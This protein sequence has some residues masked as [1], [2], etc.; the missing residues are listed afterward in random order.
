MAGATTDNNAGNHYQ[1]TTG[2]TLNLP[3]SD[4]V[5]GQVFKCGG[6]VPAVGAMVYLRTV[7]NDNSGSKGNSAELSGLVDS[8]G[9]WYANLGNARIQDLTAYFS[10]SASGDSLAAFAEGGSDGTGSIMVDTAGDTPVAGIALCGTVSPE[11]FQKTGPANGA[12]GQSTSPRLSWE[13]SIGAWG[14]E[15]CIDESNDNA[16]TGWTS[17][18]TL[19]SIVVNG[20]S[21]DKTYY[22]QVRS[23]GPG[24]TTYANGSSTAFWSFATQSSI[25]TLKVESAATQDGWILESA[26]TSS[27]GGSLNATAGSFFLGDNAAD[28]Q[29]RSIL[30]FNTSSLPDGAVITGVTLKIKNAGLVGTNPFTTHGNIA[31]DVRKGG[32]SANGALQVQDFQALASKN[33]AMTIM[34]NPVNG[35][36]SKAMAAANF[37]YINKT[38]VTQFR[39]RFGKDDNDDRGADYLKFYSGN[40]ATASWRPQLIIRYYVP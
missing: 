16:C 31:V 20:L 14:Y 7:D 2:P 35:W 36:Y 19:T 4:T 18:G 39:L 25:F 38:G 12:P 17:A 10:Y 9:Y 24:G 34:N 29:Y 22:W 13:T 1:V 32:F 15:Y 40:Y 26:E 21:A 28:S 23:S 30:S 6:N 8:N 11:P 33:T 27:Q 3:S 5:Y 37:T